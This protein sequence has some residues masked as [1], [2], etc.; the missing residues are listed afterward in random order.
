MACRPRC[1]QKVQRQCST[2]AAV[3]TTR[4]HNS[5]TV[6]RPGARQRRDLDVHR[7]LYAHRWCAIEPMLRVRSPTVS[8]ADGCA[9]AYDTVAVV[10][11]AHRRAPRPCRRIVP[12]VPPAH[13]T[14]FDTGVVLLR[15]SSLVSGI[16]HA[17]Q[18]LWTQKYIAT[19]LCEGPHLHHWCVCGC[20]ACTQ[21]LTPSVWFDGHGRSPFTVIAL[22]PTPPPL[23]VVRLRRAAQHVGALLRMTPR[24]RLTHSHVSYPPPKKY[25][26]DAPHVPRPTPYSYYGKWAPLGSGSTTTMP[27]PTAKS[28]PAR[29]GTVQLPTPAGG[30]PVPVGLGRRRWVTSGSRIWGR[31]TGGE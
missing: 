8:N 20:A 30:V 2:A 24:S 18:R 7:A 17:A 26:I 28:S 22:A 11:G 15:A 23:S 29:S 5:P 13:R 10:L 21:W 6:L 16:E 27:S 14:L 3:A 12:Y 1:T 31:F 4:R 9:V 19:V 25:T